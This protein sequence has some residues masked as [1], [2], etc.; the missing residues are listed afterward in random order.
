M[1]LDSYIFQIHTD[2]DSDIRIETYPNQAF[3][4]SVSAKDT[5]TI[6][7]ALDRSGLGTTVISVS[8]NGQDI[9]KMIYAFN[10]KGKDFTDPINM[11]G[12]GFVISALK[13]LVSKHHTIDASTILTPQS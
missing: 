13:P 5:T 6:Y 7:E 11:K 10:A 2:P 9:D 4:M 1:T 8:Q 3:W 12:T